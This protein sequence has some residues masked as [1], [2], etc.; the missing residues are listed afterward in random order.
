PAAGVI[1]AVQFFV[2]LAQAILAVGIEAIL[3]TLEIAFRRRTGIRRIRGRE[4]LRATHDRRHAWPRRWV[5]RDPTVLGE[6]DFDPRVRLILGGDESAI[7]RTRAR[8]IADDFPC[9]HAI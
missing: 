2:Q 1:T 6:P 4:D 5:E 3:A 7:V 8:E 9:R